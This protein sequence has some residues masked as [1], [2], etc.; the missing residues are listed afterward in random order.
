MFNYDPEYV[1]GNFDH[2]MAF[3]S[4][5]VWRA[6]VTCAGINVPLILVVSAVTD[7]LFAWFVALQLGAIIGFAAALKWIE[8][9]APIIHDEKK[10]I[11]TT[12]TVKSSLLSQNMSM[13]GYLRLGLAIYWRGVLISTVCY[14]PMYWIF[15]ET[16]GLPSNISDMGVGIL[17]V[18]VAW[19][20]KTLFSTPE[21]REI[22][23][24]SEPLGQ[25]ELQK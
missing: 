20:W 7:A 24:M 21:D 25:S 18:Y 12:I 9:L 6:M 8:T 3:F 23:F 10:G 22:S 13:S 1:A 11:S 5:F 14:W 17:G 16:L 2:A 15:V 19:F 4:K